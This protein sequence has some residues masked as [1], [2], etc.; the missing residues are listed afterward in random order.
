MKEYF[1]FDGSLDFIKGI[2]PGQPFLQV[3]STPTT[4]NNT[5]ALKLSIYPLEAE[6]FKSFKATISQ[7]TAT[8]NSIESHDSL[9]TIFTPTSDSGEITISDNTTTFSLSWEKLNDH[10]YTFTNNMNKISV[11]YD[12]IEKSVIPSNIDAF[13]GYLINLYHY[14]DQIVEDNAFHPMIANMLGCLT[15]DPE[16]FKDYISDK[17]F[18]ANNLV[19]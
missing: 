5:P 9:D 4:A 2:S 14:I 19:N 11:V 17:I 6:N 15:D 10:T 18:K 16:E 13:I 1:C 12:S 3:I 7:G 8:Q